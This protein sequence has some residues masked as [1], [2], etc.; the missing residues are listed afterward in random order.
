[1]VGDVKY[2][3]AADGSITAKREVVSNDKTGSIRPR[4]PCS[5]GAWH[6][7]IIDIDVRGIWET[8]IED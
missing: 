1:V 6:D 4:E 3:D 5:V 7:W 8:T 2:S